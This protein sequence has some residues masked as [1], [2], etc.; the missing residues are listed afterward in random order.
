MV[1]KKLS[2]LSASAK[3]PIMDK[4][5]AEGLSGQNDTAAR[6]LEAKLNLLLGFSK[7]MA[8]LHI[9]RVRLHIPD[10]ETQPN[11]S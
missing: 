9:D 6:C 4:P 10:R 7:I 11:A 2:A 1:R 3:Q 5:A 8:Q